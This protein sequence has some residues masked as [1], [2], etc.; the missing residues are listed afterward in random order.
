MCES[1]KGGGGEGNEAEE[2]EKKSGGYLLELFST[3]EQTNQKEEKKKTERADFWRQRRVL[4]CG[5]SHGPLHRRAFPST[6]QCC[7]VLLVLLLPL[8]TPSRAVVAGVVCAGR[9]PRVFFSCYSL[10]FLTLSVC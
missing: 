10:L 3:Q 5:G 2:E 1:K 8:A 7:R 4:V 9:A 6:L